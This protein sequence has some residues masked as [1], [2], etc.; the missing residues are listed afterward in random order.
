MNT[1]AAAQVNASHALKLC[2]VTHKYAARIAAHARTMERH[3]HMLVR[4]HARIN[5]KSIASAGT[6]YEEYRT[7]GF[8]ANSSITEQQQDTN[9]GGAVSG[10]GLADVFQMANDIAHRASK[11]TACAV[12]PPLPSE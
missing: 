10:T 3:T 6:A 1:D 9:T 8:E 7:V 4:L 12:P 2:I 11:V 5:T